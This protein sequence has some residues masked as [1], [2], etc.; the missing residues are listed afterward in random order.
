MSGFITNSELRI[1]AE[2]LCDENELLRE[3]IGDMHV[4]LQHCCDE[5]DMSECFGQASRCAMWSDPNDDCDLRKIEDRM[6][7]LGIEARK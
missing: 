1:E 5:T 2:R 3:L 4:L 6:R 7:E